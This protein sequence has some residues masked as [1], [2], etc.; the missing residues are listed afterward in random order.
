MMTFILT[1]FIGL[2][3]FSRKKTLGELNDSKTKIRLMADEMKDQNIEL[4][5]TLKNVKL[6][7]GLLP[8]CS[9]CK[10]IRDDEGYLNK[11]ETYFQKHSDTTFSHGMC[12][13]CMDKL[14][15]DEEWYQKVSSKKD[16]SE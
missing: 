2:A 12:P 11:I 13:E 7:K 14:Y 6:L 15:G 3:D 10:N 9:S 8:I 5:D 1:I 4:Q 16:N